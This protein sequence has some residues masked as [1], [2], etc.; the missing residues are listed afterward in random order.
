MQLAVLMISKSLPYFQLSISD[1]LS[2]KESEQSISD[3]L[4]LSSP[5]SIWILSLILP[6]LQLF[7][8]CQ[9][10]ST[11]GHGALSAHLWT[12]AG[13]RQDQTSVTSFV[14]LRGTSGCFLSTAPLPQGFT[15]A[16]AGFHPTFCHAGRE[17]SQ[18]ATP[19]VLL[20]AR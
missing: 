11:A 16:L 4:S 20:C 2:D 10:A 3:I 14:L 13:D 18:A 5:L 12:R 19:E 15:P 17:Q 8:Q 7:Q 6:L 1:E 9:S